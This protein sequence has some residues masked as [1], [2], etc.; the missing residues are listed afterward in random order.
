MYIPSANIYNQATDRHGTAIDANGNITANA[1]FK[2]SDYI[3]VGSGNHAII[4][5]VAEQQ[6]RVFYYE[7]D[8]ASSFKRAQWFTGDAPYNARMQDDENYIVIM[9]YETCPDFMVNL[10]DTLLP[11]EPYGAISGSFLQNK[12]DEVDG[13]IDTELESVPKKNIINRFDKATIARGYYLSAG[14]GVLIAGENFFASDYIDV[15]DIETVQ[16]SYT[17][18]VCFYDANED[19][20]SGQ[21]FN[22]IT[23]DGDIAVP[24][25]AT[26]LRF[27]TYLTHLDT[28]QIGA[29]VDR[30]NYMSHDKYTLL[31]M[32]VQSNESSIIVVDISGNGDYT[33]FTEAVYNNIDNGKPII[34]KAGT[35]D[36]AAEYVALF[37]E[38]VVDNL[39]D[40]TSG[41]NN[42]QYGIRIHDRK[43]TFEAGAHLICDWT[44]KTVNATHRF[45]ALRIE[46]NAELIGLD[47]DCTNTFYCIHDD[48][49]TVDNS[50]FTVPYKNCRVIGHNLVN[51]NC[52]GGGAHKYSR[53]ILENCYFKNN[54]ESEGL[55]TSADVRYHNT[56]TADAEPELYVSNCYFSNN[57]NVTYYGSQTT[58]M[59]AYVNNCYAPKGINKRA[60]SSNASTD[61]VE[62]YTW[63]NQSN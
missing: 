18:I 45:C 4:Q 25:G 30:R 9:L 3:Y 28:A 44:G 5:R 17:H 14:A 1:S 48:Y 37:G 31:N 57:M 52:I 29:N 23:T 33:S 39:A 27:S 54:V 32:V 43:V 35:Y 61:N 22:T 6:Y 62:L 20:V 42:F 2:V 56:N 58:K 7:T 38:D 16:C 49:G 63:N 47:L 34:V 15:S 8:D 53:H 24:D 36:I 41:I 11:Y 26:Y 21:G 60:E 50:P 19:F 13:K 46:P 10:G 40:S 51:A 12:L 59:R 55:V